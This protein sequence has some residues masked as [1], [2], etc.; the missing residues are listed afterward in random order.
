VFV[1]PIDHKMAVGIAGSICA[2]IYHFVGVPYRPMISSL[3]AL[4]GPF[5]QPERSSAV[6][7]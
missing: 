5:F 3:Y 6:C 2:C 4:V 7:R 1:I